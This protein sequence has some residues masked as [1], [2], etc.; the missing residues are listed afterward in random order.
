M[1]SIAARKGASPA[2][3]AAALGEG[4]P[5][6]PGRRYHAETLYVSFAADCNAALADYASLVGEVMSAR[7]FGEVPAGWRSRCG[8]AITEDECLAD[9]RRLEPRRHSL[10]LSVFHVDD[11]WQGQTGDWRECAAR[12]PRGMKALADDIRAAGFTPGL[13]FA[14]LVAAETSKTFREHAEWFVTG[15]DGSPR[16]FDVARCRG[17]YALDLTNPRV[18]G[19]IGEVTSRICHDWGYDCIKIDLLHFGAAGGGRLDNTKTS[20]QN[21]RR[22]LEV[23]RQTATADKYILASGCPPGPAVGIVDG[24]CV[25]PDAPDATSRALLRNWMHGLLWHNDV[26][27]IPLGGGKNAATATAAVVLSGGL[28]F[29]SGRL[30]RTAAKML[31]KLVGSSTTAAVPLDLYSRARPSIYFADGDRP[32]LGI[33]NW[34]GRPRRVKVNPR[35]ILGPIAASKMTDFQTGK[36]RKVPAGPI[37]PV[38]KPGESKLFVFS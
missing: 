17:I 31:E 23:I 13:S 8:D 30:S 26:G 6:A 10:D 11:G 25:S 36:S 19:H 20:A 16:R 34:E 35:K 5:T 21:L 7:R 38:L 4:K 2:F 1:I 24:M 9:L 15:P 22:G 14:P 33:F 32:L 28:K 12:F 3:S 27:C 37:E 18:L 29:A